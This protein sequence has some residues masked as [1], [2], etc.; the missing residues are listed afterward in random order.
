M[1]ERAF[2]GEIAQPRRGQRRQ[3]RIGQMGEGKGRHQRI[4]VGMI[5]PLYEDLGYP[6]SGKY[7]QA[8]R[9]GARIKRGEA[10][11]FESATAMRLQNLRKRYEPMLRRVFHL[12][13]RFARGM[14]LGVR[15][16]IM[17]VT[18]GCFWSSTATSPAGTCRAAASRSAK[19]SSMR[20]GANW[21]RR[22]GSN[23]GRAGVAWP[24]L[25]QSRVPPRSCRGL[26]GQAF[27]AGSAARGQPRDRRLRLL[28][29]GSLPD[30]TTQGTRLRIAEVLEGRAPIATWR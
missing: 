2:S 3:M 17:K 8:G 10:D 30:E 7:W 12:Y 19:A 22:G 26:P 4:R 1:A 6:D 20:W 16:V 15:A 18:T 13:W 5:P 28:R 27:Y 14:T 24:V 9:S 25:Q 11:T 21:R 23:F 29:V